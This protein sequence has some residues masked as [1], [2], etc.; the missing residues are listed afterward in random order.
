MRTPRFGRRSSF[1][2]AAAVAALATLLAATGVAGT[3]HAAGAV[4]SLKIAAVFS[5]TTAPPGTPDG[6]VPPVIVQAGQ[7]VSVVVNFFDSTGA[8]ASFTGKTTL[9]VTSSVG[10]S[11]TAPVPAGVTTATIPLT[12]NTAANQ[13]TVTVNA[14]GADAKKVTGDTWGT[15]FDVQ[16]LVNFRDAQPTAFQQGIGGSSNDCAEV[17]ST[18]PTCGL[19]VLPNGANGTQILLSLGACDGTSSTYAACDKKASVVQFLADLGSTAP[20]YSITS[21]A[22]VIYKCDKTLCGTGSIQNNKIFYTLSGS[23][24]I[25]TQAQA[26]PAKNTMAAPGQMCID[27]VQSKRD[28]F[29]DTYLFVLTD[30]DARIIT[31]R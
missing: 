1:F 20:L 12:V 24:A 10:D 27:F 28:N 15:P 29:G 14:T 30:R 4:S 5:G 7:Q 21:P 23:G 8:P 3:A 31:T 9:A 26:C 22:T 19:V 13:V 6:A 17:T 16:R 2:T 18:N 25:A 11:T